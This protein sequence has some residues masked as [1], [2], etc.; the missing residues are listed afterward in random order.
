MWADRA[1][2]D[3]QGFLSASHDYR[4]P[5][6]ALAVST[7]DLGDRHVA[8]W[9][10]PS[11]WLGTVRLQVAT[12]KPGVPVF[13]GIARS[14]AVN[15]YLRGVPYSMISDFGRT[16]VPVTSGGEHAPRVA[17]TRARIWAVSSSGTGLQ[18]VRWKAQTGTWSVV[19][20]NADGSKGVDVAATAGATVPA[21]LWIAVGLLIGGGVFVLIA[22]VLIV[23]GVR[24]PKRRKAASG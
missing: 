4:T 2:R 18:G 1:A 8:S 22:V 13:I 14:N 19:V 23:L 10:L 24:Q 11:R 15:R 21:L 3:D 9:G 6:Y 7:I 16:P 17:P 20:M 12:A 5:S